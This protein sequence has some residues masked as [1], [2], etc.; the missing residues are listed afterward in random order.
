MSIG[1]ALLASL[2]GML[3]LVAI[4]MDKGAVHLASLKRPE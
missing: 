4:G 1:A 3:I 2:T